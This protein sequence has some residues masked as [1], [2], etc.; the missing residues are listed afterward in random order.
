MSEWNKGQA[1]AEAYHGRSVAWHAAI[2]RASLRFDDDKRQERARILSDLWYRACSLRGNDVP[3]RANACFDAV[4]I[5][6]DK[7]E[8]DP[9]MPLPSM[10]QRH[11]KIAVIDR[12]T[13]II[14]DGYFVRL[15]NAVTQASYELDPFD[16]SVDRVKSWFHDPET[17]ERL[18]VRMSP[19]RTVAWLR[20]RR[21]ML[22]DP[23]LAA[24]EIAAD[25]AVL[26]LEENSGIPDRCPKCGEGGETFSI[27]VKRSPSSP[28]WHCNAC[29]RSGA[30]RME[31]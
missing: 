25:R 26:E 11:Q 24:K 8:R 4:S 13:E 21:R 29:G 10:L 28:T 20:R 16:H 12:A 31:P 1:M 2:R 23:E 19:A 7:W 17:A 3:A 27:C 15:T 9:I 18:S 22:D 6:T 5:L 30:L 14:R